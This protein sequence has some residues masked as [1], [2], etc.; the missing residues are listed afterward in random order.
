MNCLSEAI[1]VF[2]VMSTEYN[3]RLTFQLF[4]TAEM[5]KKFRDGQHSDTVLLMTSITSI[6][7]V[8]VKE[9]TWLRLCCQ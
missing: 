4:A 5:I 8:Q 6:I 2:A 9:G 7:Q 1:D 3:K